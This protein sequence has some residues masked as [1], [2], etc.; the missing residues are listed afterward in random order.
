MPRCSSV[1]AHGVTPDVQGTVSRHCLIGAPG[2]KCTTWNIAPT[3]CTP[4]GTPWSR[5]ALRIAS[6]ERQP[7]SSIFCG[8]AE[9]VRRM[10]QEP[11]VDFSYRLTKGAAEVAAVAS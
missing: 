1:A 11:L 9:A 10:P 5:D 6:I 2:E 8:T 4:H 3:L 7:A